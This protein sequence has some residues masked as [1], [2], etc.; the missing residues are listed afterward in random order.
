MRVLWFLGA[1]VTARAG[2][3]PLA[4]RFYVVDPGDSN[5]CPSQ[6]RDR[7]LFESNGYKVYDMQRCFELRG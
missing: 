4:N 7:P 1:F 2:L 6:F 3:L 5:V